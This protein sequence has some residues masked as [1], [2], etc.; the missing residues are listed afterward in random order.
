MAP[1]RSTERQAWPPSAAAPTAAAAAG[2]VPPL[3]SSPTIPGY[4]TIN[5]RAGLNRDQWSIDVYVK[6]L[7]NQR[8][9]VQ[10]STFQNYVPVA[11]QLNPV[12]GRMEDNA[13]IIMPRMLGISVSKNF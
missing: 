9:I 13:T 5:L 6:N 7:T 10:A 12:T 1:S 2:V 8:G 3:P 4:N 11:G